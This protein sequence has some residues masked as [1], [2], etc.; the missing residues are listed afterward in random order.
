[1]LKMLKNA[2]HNH[3]ATK[4]CRKCHQT[5]CRHAEEEDERVGVIRDQLGQPPAR[6]DRHLGV[7]ER[8]T[9]RDLGIPPCRAQKRLEGS[10]RLLRVPDQ[11][12]RGC[13]LEP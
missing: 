8:E 4:W 6:F 13:H 10:L 3:S 1:M 9:R 12:E 2:D 5:P 11:R 7:R